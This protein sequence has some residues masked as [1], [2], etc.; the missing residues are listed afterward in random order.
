MIQM[1]ERMDLDKTYQFLLIILAFL[2]PITVF[3]ANT[4]IVVICLIWLFS[5]NYK[6]KY[7]TI[8]DSKLMLASIIFFGF[9]LLIQCGHYHLIHMVDWALNLD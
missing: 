9:H 5:G 1:L 4:V 8:I 2:M 7:L 3:G 6:N